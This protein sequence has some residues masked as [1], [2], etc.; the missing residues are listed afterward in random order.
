MDIVLKLL[1]FISFFLMAYVIGVKY[2]TVI[3]DRIKKSKD[4]SISALIWTYIALG[5]R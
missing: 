5:N 1:L 3:N 4:G 2:Y